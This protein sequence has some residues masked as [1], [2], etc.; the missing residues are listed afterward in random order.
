MFTVVAKKRAAQH[1]TTGML[2]LE[3]TPAQGARLK[4]LCAR[5]SKYNKVW[6]GGTL[7]SAMLQSFLH[8]T[9]GLRVAKAH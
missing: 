4:R 5:L 2:A 6:V 1:T 7:I 8:T 9:F 3:D